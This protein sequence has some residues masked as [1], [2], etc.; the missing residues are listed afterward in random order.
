MTTPNNGSAIVDNYLAYLKRNITVKQIGDVVE[1]TLP[2]WD[3]H[4]DHLQVYVQKKDDN[5]T[6]SDDGYTLADL[7]Q[8]GVNVESEQSGLA[9]TAILQSFGVTR[10]GN[11]L[12][13]EASQDDLP[14]SQHNLVQAMLALNDWGS[15]T[16]KKRRNQI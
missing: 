14:R 5:Y 12:H 11:K 13:I 8:S 7:R 2:F 6:V 9:F 10:A 15:A 16:L 1:V 4:R 3:L